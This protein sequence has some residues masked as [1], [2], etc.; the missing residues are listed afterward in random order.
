MS[1]MRLSG[2]TVALFS[3]IFG[4]FTPQALAAEGSGC[5]QPDK[6]SSLS[7]VYESVRQVAINSSGPIY[8]MSRMTLSVNDEGHINAERAWSLAAGFGHKAD[9][10]KTKQDTELLIGVVAD[11]EFAL[12]ETEESGM[13]HGRLMDD[14]KIRLIQIQS[15]VK[16]VVIVEELGKV[17]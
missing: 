1:I 17:K 12:A 5:Q 11:C 4:A 13:Y 10:A 15:G 6:L 7:G 16:P 9:G 14:G 8:S 2:V 3:L